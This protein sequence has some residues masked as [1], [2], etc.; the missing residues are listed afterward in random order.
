MFR[1]TILL[2]LSVL[3]VIISGSFVPAKKEKAKKEPLPANIILFIGDGMGPAHLYA[4]MTVSDRPLFIEKFPYSGYV[5]T[6]SYDK[7]ITDS[8]AAGTAIACGVKTRNGMIGTAPDSTVVT[9]IMEIAHR[10]GL[11]TGLLSTSSITHAT[12]ASFVSHNTGRGNYEDI[13]T[14]FLKGTIDVFIG[15]GEKHFRDRK[16]GQDLCSKLASDG[17]DVVYNINDMKSSGSDKLAGLLAKEHMP[18]ASDGRAGML[19]E[20][21][22]KAI[23]I[24]SRNKKGFILMVEGSMID[25]GAH[26]NNFEYVVSEVIDMDKAVG[27]AVEFSRKN[28]NTLV[29][30]TAD[31]ETGGLSLTGGNSGEHKVTASFSVKDHTAAMV[32]VFSMGP[33]SERFSGIFENTFFKGQ[34][35][36]LL[37]LKE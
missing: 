4:G 30:V 27:K 15:G 32:P 34:F 18:K 9:S 6:W 12:P 35:V 29:I 28:G 24:L 16:D 36:D 7:Y 2:S 25:W 22:A 13:A 11:A 20:M 19:E 26:E 3:I 23:E 10:N 21:T 1:R 14:D 31:H 37:K 5:K 17:Y 33:G 8:A